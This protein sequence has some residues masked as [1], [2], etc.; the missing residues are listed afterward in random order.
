MIINSII[1][2]MISCCLS[3]VKTLPRTV[4]PLRHFSPSCRKTGPPSCDLP[5]T[6]Y[7]RPG[8]TSTLAGPLH[9]MLLTGRHYLPGRSMRWAFALLGM[10]CCAPDLW[11][12][13][14]DHI[15]TGAPLGGLDRLPFLQPAGP[16]AQQRPR[17]CSGP[18][19]SSRPTSESPAL[20]PTTPVVPPEWACLLSPQT[21]LPLSQ[22]AVTLH[23][24]S[25]TLSDRVCSIFH[26]PRG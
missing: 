23:H 2:V 25:L 1:L 9:H 16:P 26:P 7:N 5:V 13:C 10:L 11:A 19:C 24:G 8:Y 15:V 14:G 20:P 17:T 21:L 18:T 22:T 4:N 6:S 3:W 12:G